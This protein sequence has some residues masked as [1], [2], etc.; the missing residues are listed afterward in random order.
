MNSY[1]SFVARRIV[2]WRYCTRHTVVWLTICDQP[3]RWQMSKDRSSFGMG[4]IHT[5]WEAPTTSYLSKTGL[6]CSN[7]VRGTDACRRVLVL[8]YSMHVAA[9]RLVDPEFKESKFMKC[10]EGIMFLEWILILDH[11]N[12][13][14]LKEKHLSAHRRISIM[15]PVME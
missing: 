12:L 4:H 3:H 15:H 14:R 2:I 11:P 10:I 9:L 13:C 8:C 1:L 6:S 7:R 5:I